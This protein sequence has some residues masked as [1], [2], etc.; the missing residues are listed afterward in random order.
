MITFT[1]FDV[2]S[3]H[4]LCQLFAPQYNAYSPIN[5]GFVGIEI[6]RY[7]RPSSSTFHEED[8]EHKSGSARQQALKQHLTHNNADC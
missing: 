6:G 7:V 1:G 3:F 2:A 4:Y 5:R 8:D